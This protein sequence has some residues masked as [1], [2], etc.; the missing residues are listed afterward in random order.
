MELFSTIATSCSKINVG[1]Q[2]SEIYAT[3]IL[4]ENNMRSGNFFINYFFTNYAR[5][6]NIGK[7]KLREIQ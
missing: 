1:E 3:K 7:K 4:L 5:K 2:I 6:K